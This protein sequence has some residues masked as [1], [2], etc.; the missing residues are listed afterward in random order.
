MLARDR[1]IHH[2][3]PLTNQ[4]KQAENA[5]KD[6]DDENLDEELG[7][8]SIGNGCIGASDA[9]SDTTT[10]IAQANSQSTPKEHVS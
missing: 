2:P 9:D 4:P 10:E 7:I 8:S 1:C 6:F 5:A 3:A